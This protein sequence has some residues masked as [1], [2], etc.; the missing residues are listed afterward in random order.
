MKQ[1]D[2]LAKISSLIT[3]VVV[4]LL[5]FKLDNID[6]R[7]GN[8]YEYE[9]KKINLLHVKEISA[10][11]DY[12][13]TSKEDE[14]MELFSKHTLPLTANSITTILQ[15][16]EKVKKSEYYSAELV[17][18]MM[19]D[20]D[21]VELFHSQR[22]LKRV[23]KYR[24]NEYLLKVLKS[25]GIDDFQYKNIKMLQTKVFT[26]K[27]KFLDEV[28]SVGKLKKEGWCQENIP[29]LGLSENGI[30]FMNSIDLED[31][32]KNLSEEDIETIESRL[33]KAL[34]TYENIQ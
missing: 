8:F 30:R 16:L 11:I 32:N 9:N 25:H 19:F 1:I 13:I 17:A 3:A 12:I 22:Y 5:F 10:G 7:G 29:I 31:K 18:Y 15:R 33:N 23:E 14:Y 28:V 27:E 34:S 6:K 20:G 24:V 26:D 4:L 2:L 21:K